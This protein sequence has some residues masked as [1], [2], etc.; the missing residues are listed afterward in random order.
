MNEAREAATVDAAVLLLATPVLY[1]V[2][3][4]WLRGPALPDAIAVGDGFTR[5]LLGFASFALLFLVLPLL[6]QRLRRRQPLSTVG[7]QLG[8]VRAGALALL[9]LLPAVV[10]IANSGAAMADVRAEYPLCRELLERPDLRLPYWT[11]YALLYYVAWEWF[12]R[13]YL[14]FGLL[15]RFGPWLAIVLQTA[16]SVLVH[17]GKPTGE[18]LGAIPFGLL[19]GWLALRTGSFWYGWVLHAALGILTDVWVLHG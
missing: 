1:P 7:W 2:W 15:P 11:G 5:T 16:P 9:L 19:L 12:F 6:D 18:L 8:D 3:H 10:L 13:G 4:S 14:L 17:L